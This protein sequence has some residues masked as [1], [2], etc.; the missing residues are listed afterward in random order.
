MSLF[1]V[2]LI[3]G[4]IPTHK[5]C[6]ITLYGFMIIFYADVSDTS[7]TRINMRSIQHSIDTSGCMQFAAN[8]D[9]F[10]IALR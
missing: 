2:F 3:S 7:R 4:S 5:V 6:M 10:G 8:I 1:V 9:L